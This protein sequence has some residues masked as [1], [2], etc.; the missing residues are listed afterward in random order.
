MLPPPLRL[1]CPSK[2]QP[3]PDPRPLQRSK[4]E[5]HHRSLPRQAGW[6]GGQGGGRGWPGDTDTD[7]RSG[8][9]APHPPALPRCAQHL[10]CPGSA[11]AGQHLPQTPFPGR[12]QPRRR[13]TSAPRPAQHHRGDGQEEPPA[14]LR[15]SGSPTAGDEAGRCNRLGLGRAVSLGGTCPTRARLHPEP[16]PA[17]RGA[18][19]PSR[20]PAA[21]EAA[22]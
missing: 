3:G 22:G 20:A 2:Q 15:R 16:P 21:P 5:N 1:P 13:A 10:L 14:I 9:T 4:A 11:P 19:G 12:A 7:T 6:P 17:I 8:T 18:E